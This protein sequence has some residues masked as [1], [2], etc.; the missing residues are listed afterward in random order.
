M[1]KKEFLLIDPLTIQFLKENK[2]K[3]FTIYG[4]YHLLR[5]RYPE[6][7]FCHP[8]FYQKVKKMAKT[9]ENIKT[10]R[11]G[12]YILVWYEEKMQELQQIPVMEAKNS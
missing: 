9:V 2:G 6:L 1:P 7:N 5:K 4:L 10:E 12:N 11:L 3:K 8:L